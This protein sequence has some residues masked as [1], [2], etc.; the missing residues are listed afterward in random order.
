MSVLRRHPLVRTDLSEAINCYEDQQPGLGLEFAAD[1]LSHYG[2]LAR[3]ARLYAVRFADARRLNLDRFP[4]GLF[5]VIR[6]PEIWLLAVL[7]AS[8]DTESVLAQRRRRFR[9]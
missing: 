8:R 5:Y 9:R 3:D 7:H 1:F 6:A 4:Y 2:H